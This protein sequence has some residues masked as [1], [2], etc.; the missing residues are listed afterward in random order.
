M[1]LTQQER[2][3]FALYLERDAASDKAIADQM[4]GSGI[5]IEAMIKKLRVEAMAAEVIARKLRS[6]ETDTVT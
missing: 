4:E 3:K 1:F 2:D 5:G 6:I